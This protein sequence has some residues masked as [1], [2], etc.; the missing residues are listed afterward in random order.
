MYDAKYGRPS[1]SLGL[2]SSNYVIS[3][4]GLVYLT[5]QKKLNRVESSNRFMRAK[6]SLKVHFLLNL[7]K[8]DICTYNHIS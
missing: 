5:G 6:T 3:K 8:I 2:D 4:K 1:Q 7:I